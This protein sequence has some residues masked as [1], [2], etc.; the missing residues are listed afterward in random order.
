M[1]GVV[2]QELEKL[3]TVDQSE[4][5]MLIGKNLKKVNST[6]STR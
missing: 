6:D 1:F 2:L 5:A 4:A 3:V